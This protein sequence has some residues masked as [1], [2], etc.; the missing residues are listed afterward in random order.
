MS[1]SALNNQHTMTAP[2]SANR[3]AFEFVKTLAAEVSTGKVELPS[4]PDIA[5]RVQRALS[6]DNITPELVVR[7]IGAEPALAARIL[8]MANSAALN[9]SGK[10]ISKLSAAVA[11]MGFDMLRSSAI[12]FAMAQLRNAETYK[13]IA[14]PLNLLWQRSVLVASL[15]YIIAKRHT[16][17]SP[18]SAMLAGLLHGVGRLYILTRM[19][20]RPELLADQAGYNEI[21]RK[22]HASVAKALLE[23]WDIADE[24]VEAVHTHEDNDRD[25]RGAVGLS[26]V[27]S[28]ST[29]FASF[30]DKPDTL[31]IKLAESPASGRMQIDRAAFDAINEGSAAEIAALRSALGA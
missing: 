2:E 9:P 28:V 7:I 16:T 30:R 24:I 27:L 8:S 25:S 22:W 13:S 11:R 15:S 21:V 10:A 4:F 5:L 3:E 31:E 6:D 20:A 23:N 26:D 12:A 1:A 29:L 19:Q 17:V 18:D 14:N